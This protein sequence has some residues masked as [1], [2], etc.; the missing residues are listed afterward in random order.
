MVSW[1]TDVPAVQCC[2]LSK[3]TGRKTKDEAGESDTV[4]VGEDFQPRS[5]VTHCP[6]SHPPIYALICTGPQKLRVS[7]RLTAH[8][9]KTDPAVLHYYLVSHLCDYLHCI[10]MSNSNG[11]QLTSCFLIWKGVIIWHRLP[12]YLSWHMPGKRLKSVIIPA[13]HRTYLI[14]MK[15]HLPLQIHR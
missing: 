11:L 2:W 12:C 1:Y 7:P 13:I 4:F 8:R 14:K 3:C 6:G 15:W 9:V 10:W 5:M